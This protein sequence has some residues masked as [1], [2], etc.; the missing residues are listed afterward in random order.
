M[1][2]AGT[3]FFDGANGIASGGSLPTNPYHEPIA[4]FI[5]KLKE[6]KSAIGSVLQ[7]NF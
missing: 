1:D 7:R 6:I 5:A 3:E 2:D 4:S